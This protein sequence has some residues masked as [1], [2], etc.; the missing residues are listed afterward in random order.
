MEKINYFLV[1]EKRLGDYN[2]IDINKLDICNGYFL[3]DIASIDTFTS[4]FAESEIKA[5]IERSNMAHSDYLEGNLKI[6]SDAKHKHNL[7]VLTKDIFEN[8]IDFQD[9]NEMLDQNYKNKLF[10]IYKK[11]IDNTFEDADFIKGMLDRFKVALKNNIKD[12]I[13]RIVEELPYAKSRI[14]YFSIYDENMR[15]KEELLRKL[16]KL[17]DVA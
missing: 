13:F 10:G 4:K 2:L 15:R 9:N 1:L 17:D 3:N 16:E 12:A 14:L 6:I 5:S 8:I 7:R 11:V